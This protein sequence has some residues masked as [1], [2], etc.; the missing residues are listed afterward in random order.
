MLGVYRKLTVSGEFDD[1]DGSLPFNL[2]HIAEEELGETPSRRKHALRKLLR[3]VSEEPELNARIDSDFL[4][5]FLRVR[6]YNVD[7]AMQTIRNYYKIRTT[8]GPVFRDFLPTKISSAARALL[9]VMPEKDVHGRRIFFVNVGGWTP[10]IPFSEFQKALTICLEHL[11]SDPVTQ[12]LGLVLLVDYSGFTVDKMLCVSVGLLKKALEYFQDCMPMR[13]KAA[14]ILNQSYTFDF[15]YMIVKPVIKRKLSERE[16]IK[17]LITTLCVH[18]TVLYTSGTWNPCEVTHAVF[19]RACLMCLELMTSD[20]SAQTLGLVLLLDCHDFRVENALYL[21]PGLIKKG[22]EY[23]QDSMPSRLKAFHVVRQT[24]A[25]DILY[26]IM[27]PFL[28]TKLTRRF[29]FHG[30]N[31]ES[32][33]KDISP[34]QLPAQFGGQAPP[35]DYDAFWN[36]MDELEDAFKGDNYYGYSKKN[37]GDFATQEE[38]EEALE[39]L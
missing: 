23:V 8:C 16:C 1:S 29:K 35:L 7:A 26:G 2:Q 3:M 34:E 37:I 9:T 13:L 22:L 36:K 39:F 28:K 27:K 17:L 4:L 24:Q 12:T 21:K 30:E 38:V 10:E 14:H 5:R 32:L 20:P 15:L 18:H 31:F 19:Q 25:F 6:K 33:H 11:A